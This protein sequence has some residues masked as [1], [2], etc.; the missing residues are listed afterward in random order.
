MILFPWS[1]IAPFLITFA[2]LSLFSLYK[3]ITSIRIMYQW[4]V[5]P[6][7]FIKKKERLALLFENQFNWNFTSDFQLKLYRFFLQSQ[8]QPLDL[9]QDYS[10]QHCVFRDVNK[11]IFIPL[12][13]FF[14]NQ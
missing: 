11:P 9:L 4:V 10:F 13:Q 5:L 2:I 1:N 8:I 14:E 6:I 12:F 3:F 7:L